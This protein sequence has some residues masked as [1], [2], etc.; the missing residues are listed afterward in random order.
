MPAKPTPNADRSRPLDPALRFDA[1]PCERPWTLPIL[2]VLL[3]VVFGGAGAVGVGWVFSWLRQW[4]YIGLIFPVLI[5]LGAGIGVLIGIYIGRL[6][7][8]PLAGVIGVAAGALAYAAMHYYDCVRV[9]D[10]LEAQAR[11][12]LR[13]QL[14]L[15]VKQPLLARF[16]DRVDLGGLDDKVRQQIR[17]LRNKVSLA[18]C[19]DEVKPVVRR[20]LRQSEHVFAR[21]V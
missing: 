6:R 7:H 1:V 2:G 14:D 5:G 13:S 21:A 8:P 15:L 3:A 19:D 16:L 18:D 4:F 20:W 11:P 17:E 9:A 12:A 10:K